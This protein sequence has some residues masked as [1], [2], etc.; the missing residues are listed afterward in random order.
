MDASFWHQR[1]ADNCIG[2]HESEPNRLLLRYFDELSLPRSSRIFLPLCGKS[3]D[4]GWLLSEGHRVT[5]IELNQSAIEQ[6]FKELGLE[7]KISRKNDL[8]LYQHDNIDIYVGDIFDLSTEML[9]AVDAVYDR[10]A[11]VALP[12]EMRHRYTK[13]LM[14]ITAHAPQLLLSL[15]YDQGQMQG[16]PFS[17]SDEEIIRHYQERYHP[18]RLA[19]EA[20]PGGLKGLKEI[21]ETVWLLQPDIQDQQ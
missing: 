20:V 17:V 13:H 6:L 10:A 15:V 3:L 18:Q 5:G 16:P 2:F 8:G 1:W 19:S 7:P 9:G 14:Q 12:P 4:I 21:D 11:L